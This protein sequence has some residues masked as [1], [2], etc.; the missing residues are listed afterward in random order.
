V[1]VEQVLSNRVQIETA[2][3]HLS[4]YLNL[5]AETLDKNDA[6]QLIEHKYGANLH[7]RLR[8]NRLKRQKPINNT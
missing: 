3:K 7:E 4:L 8:N 6:V 2:L 1:F 5:A